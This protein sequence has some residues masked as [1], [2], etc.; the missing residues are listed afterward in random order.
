MTYTPQ[1]V[2]GIRIQTGEEVESRMY[3][4]LARET[5]SLSN[6]GRKMGPRI[7]LLPESEK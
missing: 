1:P 3:A 5:F 6:T 4:S 7:R 2:M